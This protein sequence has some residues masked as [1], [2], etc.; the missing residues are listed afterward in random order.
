MRGNPPK[1]ATARW[2]RRLAGWTLGHSRLPVPRGA[3]LILLALLIVGV[4]AFFASAGHPFRAWPVYTADYDQLSDS[5][6]AGH[7]YLAVPPNPQLVAK[8]NPY[9]PVNTDLWILDY[10]YYN[11]RY[12]LYWG[13]VPP[14]IQAL[15]KAALGISQ[16]IGD[17]YIVFVS[18]CAAIIAVAPML[19]KLASRLFGELPRSIVVAG[20]LAFA[21]AN[22]VLHLVSTACVYQAAISG[23]Q[24]FLWIGVAL[25]CEA[26]F[27]AQREGS[28]RVRLLLIGLAFGCALGSRLSLGLAIAAILA[29]TLLYIGP[30][31]PRHR[32]LPA[33]SF[34]RWRGG[35]IAAFWIGLTLSGCV[36]ALLLYN[37]ARFD[38]Y[39]ESGIRLQLSALP[40]RFSFSYFPANLY[41]Y[42]FQKFEWTREFPYV[43]Q[44]WSLKGGAIPKWMDFPP[45]YFAEEPHVG[46]LRVV[47]IVW[48]APLALAVLVG[49]ARKPWPRASARTALFVHACLCF[50]FAGVLGG[51]AVWGLY[52]PSMRY[53]GDFTSGLVLL[54]VLGGMT[55]YARFREHRAARRVSATILWSLSLLTVVFGMLFGYV[56]Y[57]KH[58]EKRNPELHEKLK[59]ALSL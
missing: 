27:R 9:D 13:P 19:R 6:R 10:S 32:D 36:A 45:G 1:P 29:I 47:P 20:I 55:L 17:Q 38:N 33:T 22:P 5:F 23:G 42:L 8:P 59:R 46:L 49:M 15:V 35:F 51:V 57:N 54:G 26:V 14:L 21:F 40:Y 30:C 11:G 4:Y 12:Y 41:A 18:W 25:T 58:F 56:G 44:L 31:N 53:L 16:G 34:A 7:T 52:V 48:L 24:G 28:Q 37:K 43:R 2:A 39:L 50:S 3:W